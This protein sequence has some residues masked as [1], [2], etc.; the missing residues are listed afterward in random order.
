MASQ[1]Q[2]YI[3]MLFSNLFWTAPL[4]LVS[5]RIIHL[6][7]SNEATPTCLQVLAEMCQSGYKD[8]LRFLQENSE[9]LW[10]SS[11]CPPLRT[12]FVVTPSLLGPRPDHAGEADSKPRP[13]G[14]A[15]H[16]LLQAHR[17]QQGV[18]AAETS[19]D[20]KAALVAGRADHSA[21]AHQERCD[22]VPK[23]VIF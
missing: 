15:T 19:P 8:A 17:D 22:S 14:R 20:E 1:R 9:C 21:H 5:I 23:T 10:S 18:A 16:L 4:F 11:L 12:S 3:S 6:N 2:N 13:C 7:V